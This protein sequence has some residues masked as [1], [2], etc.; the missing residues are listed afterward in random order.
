VNNEGLVSALG[1]SDGIVVN[2]TLTFASKII[3]FVQH[4]A[5]R[6][7]G[8]ALLAPS[9]MVVTLTAFDNSGVTLGTKT[10]SLNPGQQYAKLASEMFNVETFEGWVEVTPSGPGLGVFSAT[11][12]RDNR[13]LDGAVPRELSADFV[14]M[15]SNGA[16][17]IVGGALSTLWMVNPSDSTATVTI[18]GVGTPPAQ[19]L[20]I[21]A[22]S[23]RSAILPFV[24]R[25][26]STQPLAAIEVIEGP[27][28]LAL[29]VPEPS[30]GR[31][32]LT[33]PDA[34][35][36][37]DY[38][39]TLTLVNLGGAVDASISF[40]G[41]TKVVP[42][43]SNAAT[44]VSLNSL[45]PIPADVRPDAVLVM[46]STGLFGG[47][48]SLIGTVDISNSRNLVSLGSRPV[49]TEFIFPHV[50]HGGELFTG[51]CLVNGNVVTEV[52]PATIT[53]D[54]YSPGGDVRRSATVTLAV[55]QQIAKLISELV[56]SVTTQLGGYIRV[57]S[58]QP[59]LAWEIYGSND[60]FA[61]GPPL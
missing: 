11:G 6:Y 55:G 53:I 20:T 48:G 12:S 9:A 3:P 7:T 47:A 42:L 38:S 37:G 35:I 59:I 5:A 4:N 27:G 60:A 44:A 52:S 33:F 40:V 21:P 61:S 45:F 30:Q 22:R 29:G 25:V 26:T 54:V 14:A 31:A 34:V 18:S 10:V 1:V 15:H 2:P 23:R 19:T 41:T 49:S 51:L 13:D 39:S 24:A 57:R 58:D 32:N 16:A 50:A 43:P 28:K 8:I 36:G 46:T 56:P 17:S